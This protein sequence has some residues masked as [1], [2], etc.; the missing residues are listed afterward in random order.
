MATPEK[1]DTCPQCG[2]PLA[3]DGGDGCTPERCNVAGLSFTNLSE[4]QRE[5]I[6]R[7]R[8]DK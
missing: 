7:M 2:W 3:K 4:E 5:A 6:E 8:E 1:P